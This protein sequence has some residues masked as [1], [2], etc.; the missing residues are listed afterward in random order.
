MEIL[1]IIAL[2][3]TII[4]G[5]N[6]LAVGLFH[7]DLVATVAGGNDKPLA[8]VVYIIVGLCALYSI[9]FFRLF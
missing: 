4:G 5:I 8:R 3:L 1:N 7:V 6:W 2:C 9:T